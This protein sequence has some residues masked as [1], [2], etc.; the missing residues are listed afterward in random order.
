MIA[1]TGNDEFELLDGA[2][3]VSNIQIM[4]NTL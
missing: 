3:S 2:Y 4:S 1:P